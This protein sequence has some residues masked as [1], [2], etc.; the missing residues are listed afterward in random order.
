AVAAAR[1]AAAE[2]IQTN[3]VSDGFVPAAKTD[4]DLLNPWGLAA[5]STS[6]WWVND[7]HAGLSTLYQSDGTK[8]GL[9]VTVP[10]PAGSAP[11]PTSAPTGMVYNGNASE[12][13]V[14]GPGTASHF[15]F[16]TEDGTISGWNS[17]TAAVIKVDASA[18]GAI[19][20][21]LAIAGSG[22]ADQLYAT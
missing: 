10:P 3:L 13:L 16:S 15:L 8:L 17:G 12:F 2:V 6:P 20:K 7:N 21:G 14:A 1:R 4:P 19:F 18:Q 22:G 5:T 11:G 9:V